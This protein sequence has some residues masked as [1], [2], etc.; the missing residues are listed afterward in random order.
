MPPERQCK[1][2][3]WPAVKPYKPQKRQPVNKDVLKSSAVPLKPKRRNNLTLSDWLTVFA[4]IDNHPHE[5]QEAIVNH[6]QTQV[7]GAL[8]FDQSTLSLIKAVESLKKRKR[9]FGAAL[10]LEMLNPV[11]E[12]EI[13]ESGPYL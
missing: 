1:P 12:H 5:L 6:F 10:T 4:Y 2:R 9:I 8:F 3:P 11:E 13:G 7:E